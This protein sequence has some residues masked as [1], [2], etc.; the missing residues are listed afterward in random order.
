MRWSSC[1]GWHPVFAHIPVDTPSRFPP[2][3]AGNP[4][5]GP[6]TLVQSHRGH[7]REHFWFCSMKRK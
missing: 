2:S 7:L 4:G 3:Q 1:R 6:V 5:L